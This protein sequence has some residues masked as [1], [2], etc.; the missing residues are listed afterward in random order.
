MAHGLLTDRAELESLFDEL[1]AELERLGTSAEIVVV[2][3]SW[4]LWHAHRSST[5]DVDSARRIA[6]EIVEAVD[7]VGARHVLS[8]A[9]LNDDA[10]GTRPQGLTTE[11]RPRPP[12]R[13]IPDHQPATEPIVGSA[14]RFEQL[15]AL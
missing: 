11:E 10:A 1:A 6:A 14:F 2:G 8:S 12:R 5:R 4:M 15:R 13:R 3:G 7:R 9:W